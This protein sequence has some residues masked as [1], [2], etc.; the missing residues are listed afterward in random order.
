MVIGCNIWMIC[1]ELNWLFYYPELNVATFEF[2]WTLRSSVWVVFNNFLLIDVADRSN[3]SSDQKRLF[4]AVII[5]PLSFLANTPFKLVM[6]VFFI[7]GNQQ[8]VF[9]PASCGFRSQFGFLTH[10]FI[11]LCRRVWVQKIQLR[12]NRYF[13]LICP[14]CIQLLATFPWRGN[15]LI[16]YATPIPESK[17]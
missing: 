2:V 6:Y 9:F 11:H 1:L 3:I 4:F 15:S 7:N 8:F 17:Y 5:Y 13:D 10:F 14:P 12:K 16:F